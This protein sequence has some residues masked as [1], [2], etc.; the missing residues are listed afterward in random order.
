MKYADCPT[1]Q[2]S[3]DIVRRRPWWDLVSDI[4]LSRGSRP[5]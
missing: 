2:V 5:R 1:V 3:T 4:G